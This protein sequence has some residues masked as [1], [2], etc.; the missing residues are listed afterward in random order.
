MSG[1]ENFFLFYFILFI[2]FFVLFCFL[3]F[4]FFFG[5]GDLGGGNTADAGMS[6]YPYACQSTLVLLNE[7]CSTY[8]F[9]NNSVSAH[10]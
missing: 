10:E 3:F 5:G 2:I 1:F 7:V 6:V 8:P 9:I 4:V